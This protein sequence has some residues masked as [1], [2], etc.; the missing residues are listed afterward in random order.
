MVAFV[1]NTRHKP[2]RTPQIPST[3]T[4]CTNSSHP[5]QNK[6]FLTQNIAFLSPS[7]S[8]RCAHWRPQTLCFDT[9]HKNTRGEGVTPPSTIPSRIGRG[10]GPRREEAERFLA[11][12]TPLEMTARRKGGTQ[13]GSNQ[14][15]VRTWG[16][17]VQRPYEENSRTDPA[18]RGRPLQG[19]KNGHRHCGARDGSATIIRLSECGK[20]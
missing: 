19:R 2:A 18:W 11:S 5:Y 4:L 6:G 1:V 13:R 17:G 3:F 8:H 15:I 10:R 14:M 20:A 16:A 9:L 12:R 7:F